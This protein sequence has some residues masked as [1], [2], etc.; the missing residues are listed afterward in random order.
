MSWCMYSISTVSYNGTN[1][2]LLENYIINPLFNLE[3]QFLWFF[4]KFIHTP[5][6]FIEKDISNIKY[7]EKSSACNSIPL[8]P[9]VWFLDF[10]IHDQILIW[11]NFAL[12]L[13]IIIIICIFFYH[14]WYGIEKIIKYIIKSPK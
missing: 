2:F 7:I 3:F 10:T 1:I 11:V 9:H 5:I 12:F 8:I 6:N 4:S 14:I 13:C